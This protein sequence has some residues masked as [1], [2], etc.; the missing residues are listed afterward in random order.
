M[1][2][3]QHPFPRLPLL[4]VPSVKF[5]TGEKVGSYAGYIKTTLCVN[6][7]TREIKSCTFC[8]GRKVNR[9]SVEGKKCS[10][11]A[12][13]KKKK[14]LMKVMNEDKETGSYEETKRDTS[15]RLELAVA[16]PSPE[17]K[18]IKR[19]LQITHSI[20]HRMGNGKWQ[21]APYRGLCGVCA[22]VW[23]CDC[24]RNKE[25][26]VWTRLP[27]SFFPQGRQC[28]HCV[29]SFRFP[30]LAIRLTQTGF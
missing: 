8:L 28:R 10:R 6:G 30:C 12:W 5:C 27:A 9:L 1:G 18:Q 24:V 7:T 29:G 16:S 17:S 3:R 19:P 22:R 21:P 25:A 13:K 4:S 20:W 26:R 11:V 14:T 15:N 23:V 2:I